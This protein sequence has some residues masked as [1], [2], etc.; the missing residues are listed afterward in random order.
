M[1]RVR[2]IGRR[3]QKRRKVVEKTCDLPGCGKRFTGYE[4]ARYCS[5]AHRLKA[6]RAEQKATKTT[7]PAP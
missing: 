4:T 2:D 6:W 3:F 1:S 7:P 5:A